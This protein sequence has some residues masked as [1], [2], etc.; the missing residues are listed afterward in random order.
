M[1]YSLH[2]PTYNGTTD[3]ASI[4]EANFED[5]DT[6]DLSTVGNYYLLS[7]SG[8]PPESFNDLQL[9]VV[10]TENRLS[11]T[12][13][14]SAKSGVEQLTDISKEKQEDTINKIDDLANENFEDADFAE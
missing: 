13:L 11:R 2:D 12:L 7:E 10:D 3:E 5:F 9:Q 14:R 1:T 6:D 8:F 4:E